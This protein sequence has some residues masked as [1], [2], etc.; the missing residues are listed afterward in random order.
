VKLG[1]HK[2]MLFSFGVTI[3][4]DEVTRSFEMG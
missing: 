4:A 2:A 3:L 1:G